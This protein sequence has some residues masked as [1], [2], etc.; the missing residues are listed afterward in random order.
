MARALL[1]GVGPHVV[2]VPLE[3]SGAEVLEAGPVLPLPGGAPLLLGLTPAR[4][5]AVGLVS[6]AYLLDE[7]GA[8]HLLTVLC[9]VEGE[10]LALAAER[11]LGLGEIDDRTTAPGAGH[12]VLGAPQRLDTLASAL[13]TVRIL[14]PGALARALRTQLV[15][16]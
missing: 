11:S 12:A 5:R 15:L 13:G 8:P 6:L 2:A 1:L 4:G 9:R 3:D 10:P 7:P 14:S 16:A